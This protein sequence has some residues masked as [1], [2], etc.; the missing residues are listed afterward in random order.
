MSRWPRR[1]P[2]AR[3]RPLTRRSRPRP[4]SRRPK[5]KRCRGG[6]AS[7]PRTTPEAFSFGLSRNIV[8][9]GEVT[10]E[11]N[12]SGEDPHNLN[13]RLEG[14]EEPPLEIPEAGPG[15]QRVARFQL[16]AGAYRLWCS[17][18]QHEE[19]GMSDRRSEVRRAGLAEPLRVA[20]RADL[21]DVAA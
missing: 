19:W 15:E 7:K 11:L 1:P 10:V 8:Y 20:D 5:R 17:L 21:G 16:A 4:R 13:L 3:R 6:S 12:N 18:P 2:R 9:A 14:S